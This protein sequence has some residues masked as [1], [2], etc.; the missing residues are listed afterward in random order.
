MLSP[1]IF[2]ADADI[3]WILASSALDPT[4]MEPA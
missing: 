1:A 3:P 2:E 4:R